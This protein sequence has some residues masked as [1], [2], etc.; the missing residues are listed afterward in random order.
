[1]AA[2]RT[3]LDRHD[4]EL[5]P[6]TRDQVLREAQGNP[7]ALLEL[8][9][10]TARRPAGT[11]LVPAWAPLTTRVEHVFA[12]Q[13]RALP[14]GS[15]AL[16][17][18]TVLNTNGTRAETRSALAAILG[19][20]D[21]GDHEGPAVDAGLMGVDHGRLVLR[22]PLVARAVRHVAGRQQQ[23]AVHA[24]LA[25]VVADA[26]R[27]VWHRAVASAD[28]DDRVAEELEVAASRARRRGAVTVAVAALERAAELSSDP[29]SRGR[30]LI[31]AGHLAF[32][33]GRHDVLRRL[34]DDAEAL[35]LTPVDRS[36]AA[37]LR[38]NLTV[39]AWRDVAQVRSVIGIVGLLRDT[40]DTD[41]ALEA[42]MAVAVGGWWSNADGERRA[43]VAA[44]AD[45]LDVVDADPRLLVVQAMASPIDHGATLLERLERLPF[46]ERH[47]PADLRLLGLAASVLGAPHLAAA[48]LD[49]AVRGLRTQGRVGLLCDAS[50]ALAW[51][52]W[53][54][55]DWDLMRTA[56]EEPARLEMQ[57]E[58]PVSAATGRLAVAALA[59]VRGDSAS[60]VAAARDVERVFVALR[61]AP[62][63]A[64]AVLVRALAA[65]VEG[66]PADTLDE[67]LRLFDPSAVTA[68]TFVDF[69]AITLLAD[70]AAHSGRHAEARAVVDAAGLAAS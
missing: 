58:R 5:T 23:R 50:V 11:L 53:H 25:G 43:L 30:R 34:L 47:D 60:A 9:A 57:A 32:E 65:F 62:V 28:V 13:V 3:L 16:L 19:E 68:G 45:A 69:G 1:V 15:R 10:A 22:H 67:L 33:L 6:Q 20:R 63:L 66:R 7:L 48:F 29:S 42:L 70:A 17:L 36:R 26:D 14:V 59:A 2:A 12:S 27:A 51:A 21:V 41:T 38:A 18:V 49:D 55:G 52:A 37:W 56:A 54:L 24:V 39:G 31:G 46:Q 4:L 8:S 44:A 35:P 61:A 40:G 64:M